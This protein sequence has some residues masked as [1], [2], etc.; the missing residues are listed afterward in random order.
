M[1]RLPSRAA[2]A[3]TAPSAPSTR[4]TTPA[5]SPRPAARGLRW[6][7]GIALLALLQA[8]GGG[9]SGGSDEQAVDIEFAAMAGEVPV[10]CG[11]PITGL[12]SGG[13]TAALGDLRF[14]VSDIKLVTAAGQAVP[15]TLSD[16]EWQRDEIVLIDLEDGSG[17]CA[18]A[19][20]AALNTRISG[21]VPK[22]SYTGLQ[23]SVGLPS[24]LNHSDYATAA[25]PLD[26]Q[27]LAWSWQAG[28][29]FLQVEVKPQGGVSRP[30]P[31]AAS[32]TFYVH[33]GSTGCEGNPVTGETVSC[34][35]PDRMAVPLAAFNPATQKVAVDLQGLLAGSD[36]N[37]DVGSAPGCMSGL[38]D[39]ECVA[40]FSA[41][42]LNFETGLPI[43]GGA[44]Q[45]VFKAIAK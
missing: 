40:V 2:S 3:Q 29:K 14:Y 17:D 24:A 12:G 31:S 1:T 22:G 26:V 21:S 42:Q 37:V 41:L 27:A 8:C 38:L 45:R 35:R 32:D 30:P 23:F 43:D 44:A 25:A 13:V 36:L 33:L 11:T 16:S 15:V 9:G 20:S 4:R 39:P 28:R 10:A 19:G 7:A 5:R 18:G 6:P 34:A